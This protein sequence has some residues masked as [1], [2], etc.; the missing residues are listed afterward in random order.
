MERRDAAARAREEAQVLEARRRSQL[1]GDLTTELGVRRRSE[2]DSLH[3]HTREKRRQIDEQQAAREVAATARRLA[4]SVRSLP[5]PNE[6][7][8]GDR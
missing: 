7:T 4:V 2:F 5:E 8:A 6:Q 3:S 1:L